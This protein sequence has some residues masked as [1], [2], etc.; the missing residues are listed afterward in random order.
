LQ[1]LRDVRV[2]Q[3]FDA[4]Q[5]QDE[6]SDSLKLANARSSLSS[7]SRII[8]CELGEWTAEAIKPYSAADSVESGTG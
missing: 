3:T 8:A 1:A 7:S 6:L 5:A 2:G 4:D